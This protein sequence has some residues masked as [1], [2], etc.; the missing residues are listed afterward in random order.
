M[1][2]YRDGILPLIPLD[3]LLADEGA[4][5]TNGPAKGATDVVH[6][7]VC[8]S[9]AGLVGLVVDRI[10]DIVPEPTAVAQPPSRRGVS[11]SLI[12]D[13]GVTELLD[14]DTLVADTGIGIPA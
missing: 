2:Q 9:A 12:L 8:D 7:V 1:V 14:I 6:A 11:A 13:E 5:Q 3:E 10:E 4:P